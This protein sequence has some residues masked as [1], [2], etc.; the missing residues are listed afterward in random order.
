MDQSS[1]GELAPPGKRHPIPITAMGMSVFILNLLEVEA[2]DNSRVL[3]SRQQT[4]L[5]K[6][7]TEISL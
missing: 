3:A 4:G 7:N 6:Q 5:Q 2:R 1:S